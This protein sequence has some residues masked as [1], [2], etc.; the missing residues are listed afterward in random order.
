MHRAVRS[1]A[2]PPKSR[3]TDALANV[4]TYWTTQS[5]QAH[6]IVEFNN[7]EQV[8]VSHKQGTEDLD[9]DQLPCVLFIAELHQRYVSSLLKD[10]HNWRG[11]PA[12]LLL[13]LMTTYENIYRTQ[14]PG[15]LSLWR[16]SEVVLDVADQKL[17]GKSS[18][19]V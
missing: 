16:I 9:Y 7:L 4:E 19:K 11:Q 18:L 15:L 13:R 17:R 3:I 14:A 6:H 5:P 8:G 1:G 10:T 2:A 12:Q